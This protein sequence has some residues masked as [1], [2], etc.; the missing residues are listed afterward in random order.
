MVRICG[1]KQILLA[2]TVF[3]KRNKCRIIGMIE[4]FYIFVSHE[5]S[6]SGAYIIPE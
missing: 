4:V 3:R 2:D 5:L 6:F 1:N